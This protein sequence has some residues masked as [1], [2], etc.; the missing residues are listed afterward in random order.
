MKGNFF[1][2]I[3]KVTSLQKYYMHTQNPLFLTCIYFHRRGITLLLVISEVP[4]PHSRQDDFYTTQCYYIMYPTN[5][6]G[7]VNRFGNCSI[8]L[9]HQNLISTAKIKRFSKIL[10]HRAIF[11]RHK[12][13][14]LPNRNRNIQTWK[15]TTKEVKWSIELRIHGAKCK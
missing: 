12:Q 14:C 1:I 11:R 15:T 5:T 13:K 6:A 3:K 10:Y 8:C 7:H 4:T 2:Y 9:G